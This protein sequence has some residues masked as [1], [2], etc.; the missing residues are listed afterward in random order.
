MNL[1]IWSDLKVSPYYGK[2]M[3]ESYLWETT[4]LIM[5]VSSC[6][7]YKN[8]NKNSKFILQPGSRFSLD[9]KENGNY[10]IIGLARISDE[11]EVKLLNNKKFK[12][13]NSG[14]YECQVSSSTPKQISHTVK[15][16]GKMCVMH[17]MIYILFYY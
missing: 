2:K 16:R 6:W 5:Y 8:Q 12:S 10:L 15:I 4:S 3:E 17:D 9:R 13:P 14:S 7:V 1:F 11:G